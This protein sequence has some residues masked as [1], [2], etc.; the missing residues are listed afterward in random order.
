M[1]LLSSATNIGA[2]SKTILDADMLDCVD[3]DSDDNPHNDSAN[4][5]NNNSKD[6]SSPQNS[7][8]SQNLHGEYNKLTLEQKIDFIFEKMHTGTTKSITK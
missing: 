7:S 6:D 5:S 2:F 8:V 4:D 3:D 1:L